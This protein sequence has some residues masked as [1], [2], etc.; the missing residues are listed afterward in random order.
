MFPYYTGD[1]QKQRRLLSILTANRDP[2][3]WGE[4]ADEFKIRD[5]AQY[6]ALLLNWADKVVD[7]NDPKN[8][9][10]CPGK[11]L[12][13]QMTL[14]FLKVFLQKRDKFEINPNADVGIANQT[15]LAGFAVGFKPEW[16]LVP[17]RVDMDDFDDTAAWIKHGIDDSTKLTPDEIDGYFDHIDDHPKFKLI[18]R[19]AKHFHNLLLKNLKKNYQ[20][21]K[22]VCEIC[23]PIPNWPITTEN[24]IA[25]EPVPGMRIPEN[26]EDS[27]SMSELKECF[28]S[29]FFGYLKSTKASHRNIFFHKKFDFSFGVYEGHK[30]STIL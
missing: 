26:D 5:I 22:K 4:D 18:D 28:V 7:K 10:F 20:V 9:R 17:K 13:Y 12:S 1:D 19:N 30:L 24:S 29:V 2:R 27:L 8:N 14:N 25:I 6:Q 15:N 21:V 11:D 16:N 23:H 3:I